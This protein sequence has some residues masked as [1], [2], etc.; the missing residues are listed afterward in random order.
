MNRWL[1]ALAPILLT[2]L[3]VVTFL[4]IDH[5]LGMLLI[6]VALAVAFLSGRAVLGRV[7]ARPAGDIDARAVRAYREDHPG[8]SIGDAVTAVGRDRR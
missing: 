5:V 6:V 2:L 4:T 3:A 8:T 7:P 1:R